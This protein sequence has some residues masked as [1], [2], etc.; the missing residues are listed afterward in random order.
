MKD[1]YTG[2]LKNAFIEAIKTEMNYLTQDSVVYVLF[3][4]VEDIGIDHS[5]AM[6]VSFLEETIMVKILNIAT[7]KSRK[8]VLHLLNKKNEKNI[9]GKYCLLD[10][11]EIQYFSLEWYPRSTDNPS[12][13]FE[14]MIN[15]LNEFSED[16]DEIVNCKY[17]DKIKL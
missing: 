12:C 10:D 4:P 15:C 16:E 7:A 1:G 11:G 5:V 3:K 13:V 9:Y 14:F 6:T 17:V 8:D 2:K